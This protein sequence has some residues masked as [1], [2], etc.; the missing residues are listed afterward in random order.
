M[1]MTIYETLV[2]CDIDDLD[3]ADDIYDFAN[4]IGCERDK[5]KIKDP[6]DK[7]MR[8]F[9]THIEL[10]NYRPKWYSN[11]FVSEFIKKN[12][13]VFN[14]FMEEENNEMFRPSTYDEID[15]ETWYDLYM[16][17]FANLIN[18]NYSDRQYDKLYKMFGGK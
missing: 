15:D 12:I 6:Y 7:L 2:F 11:A 1:R 3:I 4:N 8:F 14:K 5:S 18:G 17:T 16:Q 13:D 10:S 9:C